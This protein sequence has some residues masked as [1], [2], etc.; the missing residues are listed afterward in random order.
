MKQAPIQTKKDFE[1]AVE[2]ALDIQNEQHLQAL[3]DAQQLFPEAI[4][5]L[6]KEHPS[7]FVELCRLA[8]RQS[9]HISR[10]LMHRRKAWYSPLPDPLPPLQS[11]YGPYGVL[12]PLQEGSMDSRSYV[13]AHPDGYY[14]LIK[15]YNPKVIGIKQ[16]EM[17]AHQERMIQ[18]LNQI[19]DPRVEELLDHFLWEDTYVQIKPYLRHMQLWDWLEFHKDRTLRLN[20]L[21]E[22]GEVIQVL[23]THN[24]AH[25]DLKPGQ[26][27]MM[28][29]METQEPAFP[30][31][32]LLIDYDFS[33]VDQQRTL[34]VGSVP[35]Y[36]PEQF[37]T[38]EK[39]DPK[40]GEYADVYA[41]SVIIHRVLS[42]SYPFAEGH[43]EPTDIDMLKNQHNLESLTTPYPP[44]TM[45]LQRGLD[46]EPSK[47]PSL[48]ELLDCLAH[49]ELHALSEQFQ[50][51]PEHLELPR[52]P[53]TLKR[54][55]PPMT[56]AL[57][58]VFV[59]CL[60]TT[61]FANNLPIKLLF[62]VGGL[63]AL[64]AIFTS[65]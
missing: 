63:F 11:S 58:I 14:C 3:L 62:G 48:Q 61:I 64:F 36:A 19:P 10:P 15:V 56:G 40:A 16:K 27:L 44:L 31:D 49:P 35:Y 34:S 6:S 18:R 1:E 28:L 59:I 20:L 24:I 54:Q 38:P 26:I 50:E 5:A 2:A 7:L 9:I 30:P 55:T 53:S 65:D 4:D 23:H 13:G 22:L 45:L 12:H 42:E 41:F 29:D 21:R 51:R 8:E 47:R 32:I 46:P 33:M 39:D 37:G 43:T 60:L 57:G 52:R 25:M 17:F